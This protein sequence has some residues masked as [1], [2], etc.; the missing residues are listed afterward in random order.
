MSFESAVKHARAKELRSLKN[1]LPSN[2]PWPPALYQNCWVF[3]TSPE[4]ETSIHT[5]MSRGGVT[6]LI[7][8]LRRAPGYRYTT[9][10]RMPN[11]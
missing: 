11:L 10:T 1:K 9:Y 5:F 2:S 6:A 4:G 8:D 3:V 7:R